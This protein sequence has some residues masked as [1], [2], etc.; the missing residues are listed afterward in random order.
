MAN[1]SLK[2]LAQDYHKRLER[3]CDLEIVELKDSDEKAG[4]QRLAREAERIKTTA[5]SFS[6]CMLLDEKGKS[7]S[8]IELS[9][10]IVALENGS[11]KKWTLIIGSSHGIHEDIKK[12]IP[13]KLQLS[14]MTLTHEWARALLL[15]QIY[16]A[17]TIK[18]NLPYHH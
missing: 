14:Q 16:R 9:K 8:S 6:D 10:T 11:V 12:A 1:Q 5:E 18:L 4:A 17:Y 7:L 3:F 2:A 15:E 13:R